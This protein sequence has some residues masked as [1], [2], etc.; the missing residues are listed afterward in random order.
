MQLLYI[1]KK[2]N[3]RKTNDVY[4]HNPTIFFIFRILI[5]LLKINNIYIFAFVQYFFFCFFVLIPI[6]ITHIHDTVHYIQIRGREKR[7]K[8]L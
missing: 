8:M 3:K 4:L 2:E 7:K 1:K 6:H 5:F